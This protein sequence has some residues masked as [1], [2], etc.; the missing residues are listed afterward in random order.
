MDDLLEE[1]QDLLDDASESGQPLTLIEEK[2]QEFCQAYARRKRR[3]MR[4]NSMLADDDEPELGIKTSALGLSPARQ[5]SVK[6]GKH[7][8]PTAM[9]AFQ[10]QK[11]DKTGRV[12][13]T[14]C[15]VAEAAKMGRDEPIDIEEWDSKKDKDHDAHL[16]QAHRAA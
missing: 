12:K 10:A 4:R 8:Y 7:T 1:L 16:A 5:C 13:Y 2:A 11:A 15:T 14:M 3:K 9:N 6:V